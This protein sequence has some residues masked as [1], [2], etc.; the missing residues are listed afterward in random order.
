M[1]LNTTLILAAA[2]L[3][4]GSLQ[5]ATLIWNN[6]NANLLFNQNGN[7]TDGFTPGVGTGAV[8]LTNDTFTIN[9]GDNVSASGFNLNVKK[10]LTISGSSAVTIGTSNWTKIENATLT[11]DGGTYNRTGGSPL[12]IGGGSSENAGILVATN[13]ASI[14]TTG[15]MIVND[16]STVTIDGGS[17]FV[18]TNTT[19][20]SYS[21][22]LA[23][24][25]EGAGVINFTGGG[26]MMGAAGY[27]FGTVATSM[28]WEALYGLGKLTFGGSNAGLFANNFTTSGTVGTTGYTL[29]AIPEP[30]SAALLGLGG[31]ALVLRRRK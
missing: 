24:A 14:G 7:W 4:I 25:I 28:T 8:D 17:S 9:N 6:G 10:G 5:A 22:T 19:A 31:L 11:V 2:S 29:T 21:G 30:S 18:F 1:K 26:T 27:K 20:G 3:S 15:M 23:Y 12:Q 16:F 13:G